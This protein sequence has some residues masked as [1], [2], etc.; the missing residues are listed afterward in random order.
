METLI[1]ARCP[2]E[3]WWAGISRERRRSRNE[4]LGLAGPDQENRNAC[5]VSNH[6][7]DAAE[8]QIPQ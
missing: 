6:V 3:S 4:Y 7:D 5:L 1:R 2:S 8:Y